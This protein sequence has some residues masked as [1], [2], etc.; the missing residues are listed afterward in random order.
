M[1]FALS[2]NKELVKVVVPVPSVVL[3]PAIVGF[4]V[5]AQQA[6]LAIIGDPP[7]VVIVPPEVAETAVIVATGVVD[8]PPAAS[9]GVIVA[10][11][12]LLWL[13]PA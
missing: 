4:E 7:S 1:V 6:P 8:T 10:V 9:M 13:F 3:L 11:R 5:V 2:P 12:M